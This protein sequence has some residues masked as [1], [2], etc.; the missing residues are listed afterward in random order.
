MHKLKSPTIAFFGFVL[1]A[2]IAAVIPNPSLGQEQDSA[3][4]LNCDD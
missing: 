3:T 2:V 1:L 4:K